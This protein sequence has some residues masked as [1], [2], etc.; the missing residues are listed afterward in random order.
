[1]SSVKKADKYKIINPTILWPTEIYAF[2]SMRGMLILPLVA[3]MIMN[4]SVPLIF[5]YSMHLERSV[6]VN[7]PMTFP[8]KLLYFRQF[9]GSEYSLHALQFVIP[10]SMQQLRIL[11]HEAFEF[12]RHPGHLFFMY[13]PQHPQY[14]PQAAISCKE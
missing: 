3:I 2:L 6:P 8:I 5:I 10:F 7:S 12:S 1:L 14:K 11:H 13:L 9:I 4:F